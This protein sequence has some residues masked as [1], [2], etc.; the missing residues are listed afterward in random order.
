L[1]FTRPGTSRQSSEREWIAWQAGPHDDLALEITTS[2][3]NF[4]PYRGAAAV[5]LDHVDVRVPVAKG[6]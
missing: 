2:A 1:T 6:T 4:E 5:E 3:M